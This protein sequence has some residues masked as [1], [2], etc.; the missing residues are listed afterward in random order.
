MRVSDTTSAIH[1]PG[2]AGDTVICGNGGS[3]SLR[4]VRAD[5]AESGGDLAT[6]EQQ[7]DDSLVSQAYTLTTSG[8]HRRQNLGVPNSSGWRGL[9]CRDWPAGLS[10]PP[11]HLTAKWLMIDVDDIHTGSGHFAN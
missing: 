3:C 9:P 5:V 7:S 4:A 11:E 1:V 8:D 10:H 2:W 6:P